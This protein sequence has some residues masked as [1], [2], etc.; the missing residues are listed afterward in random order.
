MLKI[1]C[2]AGV[3]RFSMQAKKRSERLK[4]PGS[5]NN[6]DPGF[7]RL[8]RLGAWQKTRKKGGVDAFAMNA[9]SLQPDLKN[10]MIN[11]V[12]KICSE[13]TGVTIG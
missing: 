5:L 7:H 2:H 4:L 12:K 3:K 1:A 13:K 8:V 10:L 6:L 11:D 9:E